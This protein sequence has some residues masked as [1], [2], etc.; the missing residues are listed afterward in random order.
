MRLG[1]VGHG[2]GGRTFHAPAELLGAGV[3]VVTISPPPSG[4]IDMAKQVIEAGVPVIVDNPM[5][6][7]LAEAHELVAY[8]AERGVPLSVFQNR[9]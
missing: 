3:D 8:A 4:R 2:F 1:L 9:R 5:A 6:V 7:R